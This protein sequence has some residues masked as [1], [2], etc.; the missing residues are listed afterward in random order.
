MTTSNAM[1]AQ[2]KSWCYAATTNRSICSL[3]SRP[4]AFAQAHKLNM[5]G[6][7][8]RLRELHRLSR[9]PLLQKLLLPPKKLAMQAWEE[10]PALVGCLTGLAT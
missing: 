8:L 1:S 2:S 9:L 5:L 4:G 10:C 6:L 7:S 3:L